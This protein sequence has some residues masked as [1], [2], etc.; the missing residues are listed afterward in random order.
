M[1]LNLILSTD[2]VSVQGGRM[3]NYT[4]EP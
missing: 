2:F 4:F 3:T 1:A